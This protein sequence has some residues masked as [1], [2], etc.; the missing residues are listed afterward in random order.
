MDVACAHSL[1]WNL[2]VVCRRN[3]NA[4]KHDGSHGLKP[5]HHDSTYGIHMYN[6]AS[7]LAWANINHRSLTGHLAIQVP[8]FDYSLKRST[9]YEMSREVVSQETLGSQ[10]LCIDKYVPCHVHREGCIETAKFFASWNNF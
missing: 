1:P 4:E 10:G 8:P 9:K 7:D 3:M 6:H 2:Q 5:N